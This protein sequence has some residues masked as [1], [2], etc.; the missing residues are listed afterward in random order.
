MWGRV[1]FVVSRL[2]GF[3]H[4]A[5]LDGRGGSFYPAGGCWLGSRL[6]TDGARVIH[7]VAQGKSNPSRPPLVRGGEK[8]LNIGGLPAYAL[9]SWCDGFP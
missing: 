3:R 2:A 8:S 1:R 6:N 4:M 5:G 7:V 9:S